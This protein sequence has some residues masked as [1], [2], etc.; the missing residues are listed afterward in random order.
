[1]QKTIKKVN[2]LSIFV[3]MILFIIFLLIGW[4]I[5]S[6]LLGIINLLLIIGF[7]IGISFIFYYILKE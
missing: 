5:F 7:V 1:M 4:M 6:V 3:R 2:S